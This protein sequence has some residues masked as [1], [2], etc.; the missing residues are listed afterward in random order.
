MNSIISGEDVTNAMDLRCFGIR[1]R[2]WLEKT[3]FRRR[4]YWLLGF[5]VVML[6][7][8]ILLSSVFH[9][10]DF[11]MPAWLIPG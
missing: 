9:F 11:W 8:S 6:L 4:D 3:E 7:G 10:G 2:T 5:T 1:P